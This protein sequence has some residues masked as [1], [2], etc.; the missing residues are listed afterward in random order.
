MGLLEGVEKRVES[1]NMECRELYWFQEE[2]KDN[3]NIHYFVNSVYEKEIYHNTHHKGKYGGGKCSLFLEYFFGVFL[4]F[5]GL[6]T[7]T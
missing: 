3:Y 2:N 7:G 4:G 1:E 6:G 5:I